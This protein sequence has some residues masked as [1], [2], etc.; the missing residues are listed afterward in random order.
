MSR[1]RTASES[2][3]TAEARHQPA[4]IQAA[5][6][7]SD[8]VLAPPTIGA[9]FAAFS[10]AAAWDELC[11]WPPDVFALAS[12]ILDHTESYR[13][14]VSPPAGRRWPP[15]GDWQETVTEAAAAWREAAGGRGSVPALVADQWEVVTRHR[16]LSLQALRRGEAHEVAVALLTL[17]ALADE[18]CR[19]LAGPWFRGK[20]PSFERLAWRMMDERGT[21]ARLSP[22]RVRIVPKTQFSM[23]CITIRSLSRYLALVYEAVDI[24]WRRIEAG[25]RWH[26]ATAQEFNLVLLPWPLEISARD[27]Q[28]IDGPVDM[29]PTAFGF[30]E[31]SPADRIDLGMVGRVLTAACRQATRVDA[32]ILPEGAVEEG[33]IGPLEQLAADH[34]LTFLIAGVRRPGSPG[35]LGGNYVHFGVLTSEGWERFRQAKHHR[36]CLDEQQIRQYHFCRVL[37]PGK[38]WWEGIELSPRTLEVIDL[39]GGGTIAPLVCEDLAR[40]DEVTDLLRRFGP[41]FVVALLLDGPQLPA[42][43]PCRYAS[44]LADEPGAAVLTLTSFGMA[45]RSR[46]R[47][48]QA[49]RAVGLWRDPTTGLHELDLERGASA[50]LVTTSV[51]PK[52]VW[53]GDGRCHRKYSPAVVL[54]GV[55]QLRVSSRVALRRRPQGRVPD[56]QPEGGCDVE[57]G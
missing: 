31:F 3:G 45:H 28:A 24:R 2:S 42:R 29:D 54:S 35:A 26:A 11:T 41:S 30:F 6:G 55:H 14:A 4:R 7:S 34:G 10:P 49:S 51:S 39:G 38:V 56:P 40:M 18:A 50:L 17:H 8:A 20:E 5:A 44:V 23:R 43:W 46:P 33:D 22:D 19:G 1:A 15:S 48:K 37:D 47:G 21:L 27:F 57:V 52:V 13:L 12:L 32:L 9:Y 25:T 53:T 16:D 36:W